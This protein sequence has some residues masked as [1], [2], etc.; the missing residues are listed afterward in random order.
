MDGKFRMTAKTTA[1]IF[2]NGNIMELSVKIII[3]AAQPPMILNAIPHGSG[4]LTLFNQW[5]KQGV[6]VAFGTLME[7]PTLN[8]WWEIIQKSMKKKE[9]K[10]K[11]EKQERIP[12]RDMWEPFPLTDVQE[13]E[14]AAADYLKL[15]DL[16]EQKEALE[17]EILKLYGKWEDL[18]AQLEEARG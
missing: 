3:S 9:K 13:M 11:A 7:H 12:E 2:L 5:R 15:Q 8:E 18:S 6:K 10:A 17:E 16:Y 4:R 1:F 14:A